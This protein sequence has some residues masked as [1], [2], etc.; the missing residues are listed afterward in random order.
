[1]IGRELEQYRVVEALGAGGMGV[2]Y[3]A[4]D[5]RLSRDVALKVLPQGSLADETDFLVMELVPG[6]PSTPGSR[7][8]RHAYATSTPVDGPRTIVRFEVATGRVER[9][10]RIDGLRSDLWLELTPDGAPMVHR[11]VSQREVVVMDWEVR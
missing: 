8:S 11:D 6:A 7:D 5:T 4:H 3:R 9:P 2:V 10:G 1:V